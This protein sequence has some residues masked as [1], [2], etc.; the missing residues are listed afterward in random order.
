MLLLICIVY[1]AISITAGVQVI[2]Y[3]ARMFGLFDVSFLSM[4]ICVEV[5]GNT[6]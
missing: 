6:S 1:R 2:V 5:G 3:E 4:A